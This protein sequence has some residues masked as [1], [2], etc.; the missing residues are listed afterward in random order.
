[1]TE[2]VPPQPNA[3]ILEL[4]SYPS[5]EPA[6]EVLEVNAGFVKAHNLQIGD[7][8]VITNTK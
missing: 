5:P 7:R 8:V 2:N 1:M 6:D 3:S 4:V